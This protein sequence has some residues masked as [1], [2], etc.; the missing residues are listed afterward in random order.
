[1]VHIFGVVHALDN[2]DARR[3]RHQTGVSKPFD[4]RDQIA[5]DGLT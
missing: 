5:D 1:M 4:R 2:V 3:V